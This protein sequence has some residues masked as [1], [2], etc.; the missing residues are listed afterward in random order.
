MIVCGREI[1]VQGRLIRLARLDAEKYQFL[2]EP[3]P[4]LVNLRKSGTRIDLFTFLQRLPETSPKFSYPMEWDNLAVLPVSTFDHWWTN[5]IGFKLRNKAR[6]AAKKGVTSREVPFDAPLVRGMWEVYNE[7][8]VRQGKPNVHYGKDIDTVRKE[9]ATYLDSSIFIAAFL[10]DKL[11]GFAKLVTDETGS[12]AGLMNIVAMIKHRDKAP[13]NELIAQAVR[14]CAAR[15]ISYL[16]YSRFVDGGK[17]RDSLSDFKESNGFQ[18]A[19][20][21]RYYVPLTAIGRAALQLGLHRPWVDRLP[22]SVGA[23]LRQVRRAWYR[24][25]FQTATVTS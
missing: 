19:D 3:E 12:Q 13:T 16:V 10:A 5:Q 4:L 25:K 9:A 22:E 14:A 1:K 8:P 7:S 11:I 17:Q 20:V 6:Q 18:R 21:P 23:K 15:K 2:E 24:R